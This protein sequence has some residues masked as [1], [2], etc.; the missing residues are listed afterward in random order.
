MTK[1]TGGPAFPYVKT[2]RNQNQTVATGMT[3]LDYFAAKAMQ[4]F[5]SNP[6]VEKSQEGRY[7]LW[8]SKVAKYSYD[9]AEEMLEEK[10]RRLDE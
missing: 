10:E 7:K 1:P 5:L 6:E 2:D 4:G 9:L 8:I 3:K